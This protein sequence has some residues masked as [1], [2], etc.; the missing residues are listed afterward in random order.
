MDI[1]FYI[2]IGVLLASL[3][4]LGM[5]YVKPLFTADSKDES[6]GPNCKCD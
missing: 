2:A 3:A 6:C 1:Q 4:F 5:K